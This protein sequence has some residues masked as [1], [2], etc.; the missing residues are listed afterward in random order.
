M[1][2]DP[3]HGHFEAAMPRIDGRS[4]L[5]QWMIEANTALLLVTLAAMLAT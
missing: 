1:S 3:S 2:L 5:Q 4:R